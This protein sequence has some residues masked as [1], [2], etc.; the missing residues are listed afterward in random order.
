MA[1][2]DY[3]EMYKFDSYSFPISAYMNNV[4]S[5]EYDIDPPHQRNS[6][7]NS[8]KWNIEVIR[9]VYQFRTLTPIY[10]HRRK[11]DGV[12]ENLD[13]KQRTHALRLY[14]NGEFSIPINS[15]L[16]PYLCGKYT[17]LS[18]VHK[19]RFDNIP[20]MLLISDNELS[21]SDIK[22]FFNDVQKSS[23]TQP[24]ER[25]NSDP[26]NKLN[27]MIVRELEKNEIL[28]KICTIP[29]MRME[30]RYT[31]GMC[32]YIYCNG[33]TTKRVPGP[34][35]V[36]D[37][38]SHFNDAKKFREAMEICEAVSIWMHMCKIRQTRWDFMAF[39][40]LFWKSDDAMVDRIMRNIK[41]LEDPSKPFEG[42][43]HKHSGGGTCD[44]S[45]FL[46]EK[47]NV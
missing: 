38:G 46:I 23:T 32:T 42:Y 5:G 37:F 21:T 3:M 19:R 6:G 36:I 34:D 24:G 18:L 26:D 13:G 27:R 45:N 16:P 39:F 31:L 7:R 15:G 28:K 30:N 14:I 17:D 2:G 12:Y 44:R 40:I 4:K 25:M 41:S 11:S 22:T 43:H 29:D 10:Y 9:H 47:Y 33:I 8:T 1:T 35:T 20:V